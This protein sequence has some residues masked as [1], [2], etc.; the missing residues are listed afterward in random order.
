MIFAFSSLRSQD[1]RLFTAKWWN[2]ADTRRSERRA[3]M[4]VGVQ[5][6]PWSLQTGQVPDRLS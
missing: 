1:S 5:I 4:G 2:L 3:R 6:S